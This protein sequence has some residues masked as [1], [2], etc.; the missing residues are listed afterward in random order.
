MSR[1]HNGRY[2]YLLS[3]L[4]PFA[5]L[6]CSFAILGIY[7]FG[8]TSVLLWD[9]DYQYV[10]YFGWLS[11][12]LRGDGNLT[13]SFSKG[14]GGSMV[15]LFGY[16]LSSPFNLLAFFFDSSHTP[17]LLSWLTLIKIPAAS[18]T[19]YIFLR[20][21]FAGG[22]PIFV[23]IASAYALST[24]TIGYCSN[25]MW[26]DGVIMLPLVAL[27]VWRLVEDGKYGVLFWSVLCA[28]VFNWYT[29]YMVCLFSILYFIFELVRK[30]DFSFKRQG[31][32]VW[33]RAWHYMVSML[34]GVG[35]SAFLFLPTIIGLRAGKGGDVSFTSILDIGFPSNPLDFFDFL[36]VGSMPTAESPVP[37]VYISALVL[38]GCFIYLLNR[39]LD[40][41]DRT[42]HFI[43]IV[44][45]AAPFFFLPLANL[46][47]GFS[48]VSSYY[49]RF[50][51]VFLFFTVIC[52]AEGFCALVRLDDKTCR[53]LIGRS[54][55]VVIALIALSIFNIG[56]YTDEI[57]PAKIDIILEMLLLIT[58]ACL[59]Y[60]WSRKRLHVLAHS[61]ETSEV[62][63]RTSGTGGLVV[64][65]L[66]IGL[67]FCCEQLYNATAVFS[68]YGKSAS[69]YTNYIS[70][71]QQTY[72]GLHSDDRVDRMGQAGFNYLGDGHWAT[73]SE[74]LVLGMGDLNHYSSTMSSSTEELM[75]HLGYSKM[76]IFG[77]YY[78]SPL[79]IPD[80]LL[81]IDYTITAGKAPF[82]STQINGDFPYENYGIYS[83]GSALSLGYRISDNATGTVDWA[84]DPTVNQVALL[85]DISGSDPSALMSKATIV[86]VTSDGQSRSWSVTATADG[87]LY[88]YAQGLFSE[89]GYTGGI[90]AVISTDDGITQLVGGRFSCN[91]IYLGTYEKGQ[92][93][94]VTMT[95]SA[96]DQS[97]IGT[98]FDEDITMLEYIQKTPTDELID[99][100]SLNGSA[101][102]STL[103]GISNGNC[104]VDSFED[105]A[106]SLSYNATTDGTLLV[107]IPY[108]DGWSATVNG[109]PV[110]ISRL[111]DSLMGIG[112]STGDNQI[113]LTYRAP[114]LIPGV[115]ISVLC[116]LIFLAWRGASRRR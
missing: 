63:K 48:Q 112:V 7:P 11:N 82:G 54:L 59:I 3:Y 61:G 88:L 81:G 99:V 52:A 43:M 79:Y 12:V 101:C 17:Q 62:G 25:I 89:A 93:V 73:T 67:V 76:S 74:A 58:F 71:M 64:A 24:Y 69:T 57:K 44:C 14:I 6:L 85:A 107:T 96:P 100:D 92:T 35:G 20:K 70:Q 51:F 4:I 55:F 2:E 110:E 9:M 41:R 72:A 65:V 111:Y 97:C 45:L 33:S 34:L 115:A 15:A 10:G 103:Q 29:G 1:Q 37:A 18:L 104:M 8:D 66:V 80:S 90:P 56:Y 50:A 22:S 42:A 91:A 116:L 39:D 16:Y 31:R 5:I 38:L 60:L 13:Y 98:G 102:T 26:L 113:V 68:Q 114:G 109:Q 75:A 83:N 94:T 105:G 23:L 40:R 86:D 36:C 106:V 95:P 27:G 77:I 19:C 30:C 47:S 53:G 87:P 28:I 78:N 84:S 108:D 32:F 46:W 49:H 21:R